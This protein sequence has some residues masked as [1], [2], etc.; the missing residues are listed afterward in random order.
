ME[1]IRQMIADLRIDTKAS[2]IQL[3]DLDAKLKSD[4]AKFEEKSKE[5]FCLKSYAQN[6]V[7]KLKAL[8][9]HEYANLEILHDAMSK[10]NDKHS[11]HL[12]SFLD[13]ESQF[14]ELHKKLSQTHELAE[15]RVQQEQVELIYLEISK[16][17][18]YEDLKDLYKKVVPPIL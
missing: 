15:S 2:K 4:F 13:V 14:Q 11:E 18:S 17:C 3:R 12:S 10:Q 8:V 9:Q 16:Y 5:V 7:G 1:E 6:E